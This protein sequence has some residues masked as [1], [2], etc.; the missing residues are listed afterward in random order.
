MVVQGSYSVF[1]LLGNIYIYFQTE[2]DC[3]RI[4]IRST[5]E[6]IYNIVYF[7]AVAS[8]VARLQWGNCRLLS[9]SGPKAGIVRSGTVQSLVLAVISEAYLDI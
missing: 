7:R 1:S 9:E 5:T 8:P 4:G 2:T 3:L 6:A